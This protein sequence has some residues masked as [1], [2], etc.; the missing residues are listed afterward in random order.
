[1]LFKNKV[2]WDLNWETFGTTTGRFEVNIAKCTGALCFDFGSVP[3]RH[4]R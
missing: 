4:L 2:E 1:M 3:F